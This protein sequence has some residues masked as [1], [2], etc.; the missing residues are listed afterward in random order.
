MIQRYLRNLTAIVLLLCVSAFL[1]QVLANTYNV[2][3]TTDFPIS[4]A[5]I[6]V[7][8]A[9][10]IITGGAGNGQ[11]TLRSAI[12]AANNVAG[13]HTINLPGGTFNLTIA[14]PAEGFG[15]DITIGDLDVLMSGITIQGAGMNSTIINQTTGVE[16]VFDVN[17]NYVSGTAFN[18]TIDGVTV[19]GGRS[20][21]ANGFSEGGGIFCG[22]NNANGLTTVTNCKFLN[23]QSSGAG[24]GGGAVS[25]DGG[26]QIGR[27]HV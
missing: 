18:F 26:N 19:S 15:G 7:A 21:L 3:S 6:S 16:R 20:S 24:L 2:T 1:N 14:G 25:S 17:V 10:G 11:I 22:S 9:T 8:N 23:N 13:P 27:A 5:G 12:A 4:G